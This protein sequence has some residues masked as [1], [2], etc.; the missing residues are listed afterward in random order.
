M[1]TTCDWPVSKASNLPHAESRSPKCRSTDET[2]LAQQNASAAGLRGV[3][4]RWLALLAAVALAYAPAL[5]G[6]FVWDDEPLVQRNALIRSPALVGEA[7]RHGLF[8]ENPLSTH[9]RPLQTVTYILDYWCWELNPFGYHLT[10]VLLQGFAAGLLYL[11]L[12]RLLGATLLRPAETTR[13]TMDDTAFVVALL[14]A[15]HP[16]HNAAVAYIAGR[17]DPLSFSLAATG[18]LLLF[19]ATAPK[20]LTARHAL[21]GVFGT[22]ALFAALASRESAACWLVL[23]AS[24]FLVT[25]YQPAQRR[26]VGGALL[27]AV[28][29]YACLRGLCLIPE[30][31]P[32][33]SALGAPAFDLPARLLLAL[34]ALANY[35]QTL[36]WPARLLMDRTLGCETALL[37]PGGSGRLALWLAPATLAGVGLLATLILGAILRRG[38]GWRLRRLGTWW[39]LVGFLPVSNLVSLN[40]TV[41]DHWLYLPSV[42]LLLVL[43]GYWQEVPLSFHRLAVPAIALAA[44]LLAGRTFWRSWDWRDEATF[45]ART[46]ADGGDSA[47]IRFNLAHTQLQAGNPAAAETTLIETLNQF[48]SFFPARLMADKLTSAHQSEEPTARAERLGALREHLLAGGHNGDGPGRQLTAELARAL[49]QSGKL[50]AALALAEPAS[51][52]PSARTSRWQ[53][54]LAIRT[55]L[56]WRLGRLPEALTITNTFVQSHPWHQ[57]AAF[58]LSDLQAAAGD[59]IGALTTL[60][61]ADTLDVH[62]G[63]AL[64][65][66]AVLYVRRG[67]LPR[68]LACQEAAVAVTPRRADLHRRLG[69]VCALLHQE[70]EAR[71]EFAL[72]DRLEAF[73]SQIPH[74]NSHPVVGENIPG[75]IQP[76]RGPSSPSSS[77]NPTS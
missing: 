74:P 65:R 62:G 68:A 44:T 55:E 69:A 35:G 75:V 13:G 21:C 27:T 7:F 1:T 56:L 6:G 28:G 46:I 76:V 71:R 11:L 49:L 18:W 10:N 72:A 64:S 2:T 58:R 23:I 45:Y 8:A 3:A 12:C 53:P 9:Y 15:V 37:A 41:A 14:W 26:L 57:E 20:V 16:A 22:L 4:L 24:G 40:A 66:M 59:N 63:E 34:R 51:G 32:A 30:A 43:A 5:T 39:F 31:L 25:T 47:R 67:D 19:R 36:L 70:E 38:Q 33:G 60:S 73:S 48:P 17:A 29:G 50:E 54:F 42:G 61:R 52:L 77:Q